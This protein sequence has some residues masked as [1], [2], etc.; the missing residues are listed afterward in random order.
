MTLAPVAT[1]PVV[2]FPR[3]TFNKGFKSE[4][5]IAYEIGYRAQ[6]MAQ[7][8][9][10]VAAF[11]N[12]HDNLRIGVFGSP[13]PGPDGTLILP[14]GF[15]NR[16]KGETYGTELAVDWHPT[17]WWRLY[18][19]YIF[20]EMK[21]HADQSLPP[22]IITAAESNQGHNPQHQVYLQSSWDVGHDVEVDLM[23]RYVSRLDGFNPGNIQGFP[24]AIEA[25][26]SMDAR[27]AWQPLRTLELSVVGQNLLDNHHPEFSSSPQGQ[28]L[29]NPLAEIRRSV[30]G[31]VKWDF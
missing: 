22:E 12:D 4:E 9:V 18:G 17:K 20:L 6:P 23:G 1:A 7:F 14:L 27:I 29:R 19:S 3:L 15:D 16:L 8:S 21:L 2:V 24:D 10:D 25:Y 5:V 30:Y 28:V 31:R 26:A 13:T 11:Y